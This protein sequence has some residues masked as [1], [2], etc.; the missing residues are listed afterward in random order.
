MPARIDRQV[1]HIK[2]S[3]MAQGKSATKAESIAWGHVQNM[4]K[5]APK[6]RH[7]K[8][9]VSVSMKND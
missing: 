8:G 5:K 1:E 4:K 2:Q 7:K 3:E 6:A 9:E